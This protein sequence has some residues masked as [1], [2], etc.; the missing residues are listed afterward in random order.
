[1]ASYC[2]ECIKKESQHHECLPCLE[3]WEVCTYILKCIFIIMCTKLSSVE[4]LI[5][6]IISGWPYVV[7]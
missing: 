7:P 6:I 3:K 5:I 2:E 1:M 4:S